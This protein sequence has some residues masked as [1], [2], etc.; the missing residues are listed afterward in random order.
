MNPMNPMNEDTVRT[1]LADVAGAPEPPSRISIESART[2]GR[3]R[4]RAARVIA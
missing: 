4:Q 1:L 2:V 3:R